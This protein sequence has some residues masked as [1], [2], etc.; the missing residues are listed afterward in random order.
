MG[1]YTVISDVGNA[2]I[3]LLR[4]NLTP[5]PVLNPDSINLC[6]PVDNGNS[7][8]GLYLYDL[9]ESDEIRDTEMVNVG[10]GKQ[11]YP[12]MNLNLFYMM[13][14]YSS[15]DIKFRASDDHL[16]LGKAIQIL[17]DY[18]YIKPFE[19]NAEGAKNDKTM[20]IQMLNLPFEEKTKTWN[21]PNIPYRLSVFYK[22]FPV[23]LESSKIKTV[24]RVVDLNITAK[25]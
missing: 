24:Q 5:Q 16:I 10:I 20:R 6:T 3:K 23:E 19:A 13:T 25:E 12:S 17:Y 7:V 15:S 14:A 21:F 2:I 8:L 9:K 4:E 22:V 18:P 1:R 11:K